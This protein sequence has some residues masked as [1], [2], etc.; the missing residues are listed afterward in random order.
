MR[1]AK[2]NHYNFWHEY[3]RD[4]SEERH[5]PNVMANSSK[6]DSRSFSIN[7]VEAVEVS[8]L[9]VNRA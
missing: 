1:V 7:D 3:A 5:A 2:F 6:N 4:P 8:E 9:K